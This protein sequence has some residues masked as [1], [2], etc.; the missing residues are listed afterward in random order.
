MQVSTLV[1]MTI[2]RTMVESSKCRTLNRGAT[3]SSCNSRPVVRG[4]TCLV[5]TDC[6]P[7]RR[8]VLCLV[9]WNHFNR[10]MV[11]NFAFKTFD[12]VATFSSW[13]CRPMVRGLTHPTR[14]FGTISVAPQS[15]VLIY[16]AVISQI[17]RRNVCPMVT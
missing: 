7:K 10:T 8:R 15:K 3:I 1:T 5:F 2:S 17:D 6:V 16:F 11:E 9:F 13:N 12:C 4:V 14:Y